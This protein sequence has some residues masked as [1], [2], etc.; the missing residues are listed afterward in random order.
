MEC[1]KWFDRGGRALMAAGTVVLCLAGQQA[2]AET[3]PAKPVRI[4][5]AAPAGGTADMLARSLADGLTRQLGQP[6]IVDS[7]PGGFG[8]I[9]VQDMLAAPHDG[10]TLLV[11]Q[12][13]IASEAP[14]LAK[15]RFDPFKDIKPVAELARGGLVLVGNPALPAKT[16]GEL[17]SYVKAHPASVNYA[18]YSTGMLGHTMGPQLNE[19]A[20]IDMSHVGY[21]GSPP[22]LQD[23][24]GGHVPL[25]FDGTATSL[26]LI[27][28]GKLRAFAV[29]SPKRLATL[30]Q[31]PTFTE[32]GYPALN[33]LAW[34]G[35][36]VAPDVPEAIQDRLRAATR[37]VLESASVRD[38]IAELGLD[39]GVPRSQAEL[40][41]SL[42]T[43]HDRQGALLKAID[44]KPD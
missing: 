8:A 23:V 16:L 18:S 33:Q 14:F 37:K 39:V 34:I 19:L 27:K 15:Q 24:M 25:M 11:I 12:D 22:A 13:G 41:A 17:I 31:V 4:V 42:R 20:G 38:R 3:W 6:F 28:A 30:P 35:V 10:Y 26:P 1:I 40:G 29:S 9:A 7:K 43:A 5:T 32:L 21:K 2:G 36:W 44:F